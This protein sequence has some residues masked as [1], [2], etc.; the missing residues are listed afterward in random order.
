MNDK[1]ED[2]IASQRKFKS[3]KINFDGMKTVPELVGIILQND[4]DDNH[5]SKKASEL[6]KLMELD[7]V[8]S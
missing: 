2:L 4:D 1:E 3:S 6:E 5:E 7:D 8:N